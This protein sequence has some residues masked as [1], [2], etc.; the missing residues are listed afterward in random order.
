MNR[1]FTTVLHL[2]HSLVSALDCVAIEKILG[3]NRTLEKNAW[4]AAPGADKRCFAE[5]GLFIGR[6]G[7]VVINHAN[8]LSRN[9]RWCLLSVPQKLQKGG[10]Q[11]GAA[12]RRRENID[13]PP[14]YPA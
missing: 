9:A 4:I 13:P 2:P 10:K 1:K 14:R 11:L 5:A 12:L 3:R 8:R 7:T 6:G